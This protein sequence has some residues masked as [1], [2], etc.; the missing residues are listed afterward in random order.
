MRLVVKPENITDAIAL[1]TRKELQP[2]LLG[3]LGMGVSQVLVSAVRLN[4]FDALQESPKTATQLAKAMNCDLHGMQVLLESLD[5][6]G[7]VQRQGEKYQLT[8]ESARWLTKSGGFIQDF[9]RLGGDISQQM[10]LLE[11]DVRTGEV[12]NFHFDPQSSTCFANYYNMLK[13]GNCQHRRY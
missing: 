2:F 13:V 7:F 12:P 3:M 10:V 4:V 8:R 11:E 6:F 9:L 1:Q 5:G